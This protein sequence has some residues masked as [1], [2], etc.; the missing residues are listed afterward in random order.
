MQ[1]AWHDVITAAWR[2]QLE[3]AQQSWFAP[4]VI[5]SHLNQTCECSG[6]CRRY[7]AQQQPETET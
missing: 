5:T 6:R 3:G 7:P 1:L 2:A 4:L